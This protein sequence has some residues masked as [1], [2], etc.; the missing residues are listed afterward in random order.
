[1]PIGADAGQ[2]ERQASDIA[3]LYTLTGRKRLRNP[4]F[5]AH[6]DAPGLIVIQYQTGHRD[7]GLGRGRWAEYGGI[8]PARQA[9]E[10]ILVRQ[11]SASGAIDE[12]SVRQGYCGSLAISFLWSGN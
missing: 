12:K 9:R 6:A 5:L 7:Q 1:M 8:I 4:D 10:K 3:Q 2:T 11:R